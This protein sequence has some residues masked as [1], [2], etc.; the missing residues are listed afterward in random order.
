MERKI[1]LHTHSAASDGSCTPSEIVAIAAEKNLAAV[2][3]TDHDTVAGIPEFLEACSGVGMPAGVP[4]VE[5]S[6]K[7]RRHTVHILG[8]FID[9]KASGL[10]SLLRE[11]RG[12]RDERNLRIIS[13]LRERGY[14][15]ELGE[16]LEVAGGES[17]GR[18]HFA[19]V[20]IDKGHF[21]ETQPV[22]DELLKKGSSCYCSRTLPSPEKAISEIHKAKGLAI[23]AHP[24]HRAGNEKTYVLNT[25]KQLVKMGLD[26]I[27]T[28][29]S[30][31]LPEQAQFLSET[32][33]RYGLAVSG[34]SDFHGENMS[35]ID[36]GDGMGSLDVREG[37]YHELLRLKMEIFS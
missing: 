19:K 16:V 34:G 26:G 13:K 29:Y 5:F 11:I 35:G 9:H 14:D 36:M 32:A 10:L 20:L 7:Y 12:S 1:D 27:E 37:V 8:L 33:A 6:V 3:L 23:W 22:F 24:V 2:A 30:T 21:K 31:Y 25:L 4:G 18:P 17:V 28:A 15:I